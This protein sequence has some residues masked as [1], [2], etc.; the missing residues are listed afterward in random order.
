MAENDNIPNPPAPFE[1]KGRDSDDNVITIDLI[2]TSFD[3]PYSTLVALIIGL[4]VGGLL[5][6][7]MVFANTP[8]SVVEWMA[9]DAFATSIAL[10][11]TPSPPKPDE[12]TTIVEQTREVEV[13][14]LVEVEATVVVPVEVTREIE[15][16]QTQV[17][18]VVKEVEVES[19]VIVTVE[20]I[21]EVEVIRPQIMV[22]TPTPLSIPVVMTDS[23]RTAFQEAGDYLL[24]Q[25]PTAVSNLWLGNGKEDIILTVF[26]LLQGFSSISDVDWVVDEFD[27]SKKED[28]FNVY[29]VEVSTTLTFNGAFG[30]GGEWYQQVVNIPYDGNLRIQITTNGIQIVNWIDYRVESINT[31]VCS[32]IGP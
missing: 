4:V 22:V 13:T 26:Q 6:S 7:A 15:V 16:V 11:P 32:T 28:E 31:F 30:C 27:L 25:D 17:V 12:I 5:V 18:E 29:D 3:I 2:A 9:G 10:T 21:K 8:R 1:R 20:V 14:S 19:T 23:I 24:T